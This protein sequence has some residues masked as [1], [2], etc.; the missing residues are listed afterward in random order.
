[1]R[2]VSLLKKDQQNKAQ[3]EGNKIKKS[4]TSSVINLDIQNRTNPDFSE[5]VEL[6]EFIQIFE[7][8]S[9]GERAVKA[10]KQRCADK[11]KK[12]LDKERAISLKK[13]R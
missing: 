13:L 10:M 4:T 11:A 1:M 2:L 8:D 12:A 7:K 5:R 9:F 3:E 6:K